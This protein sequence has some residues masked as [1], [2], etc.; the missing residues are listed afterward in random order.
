MEVEEE[1]ERVGRLATGEK[2]E[3]DVKKSGVRACEQVES[4]FSRPCTA[5]WTAVNS[6]MCCAMVERMSR[7]RLC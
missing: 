6:P 3:R 2:R 7:K 5:K 4:L 1:A